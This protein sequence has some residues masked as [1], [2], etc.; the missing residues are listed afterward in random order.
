MSQTAVAPWKNGYYRYKST[1]LWIIKVCK[2]ECS[3]QIDDIIKVIYNFGYN[4]KF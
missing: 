2:Q 3:G 4:I 1:T